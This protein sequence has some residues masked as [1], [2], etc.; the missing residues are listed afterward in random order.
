[1]Y[2]TYPDI[3]RW[4]LKEGSLQEDISKV[5]KKTPITINKNYDKPLTHE[6]E[7]ALKNCSD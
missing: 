6:E 2:M 4:I 5:Y 3:R 7:D 1:M